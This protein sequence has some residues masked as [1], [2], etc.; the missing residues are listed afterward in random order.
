MASDPAGIHENA[1][2]GGVT[3]PFGFDG[4]SER[5]RL[6]A[7]GSNGHD[8]HP[9]D[10]TEIGNVPTD[11]FPSAAE[12]SE[13][14][15]DFPS[16]DDDRDR[17]R[18]VSAAELAHPDAPRRGDRP[19]GIDEIAA[20]EQ[21]VRTARGKLP[22][23]HDA[24]LFEVLSEK[25]IAEE[26]ALAEWIRGQRRK[27]RRRAVEEEL[28]VEARD[29][30]TAAV[31]QRADEA[32]A[33]WHRRA[34]AARRRVSSE[35][36]RLAQLFRRAEWSSRAL[37][38]VVVLGMVWAGV[39][40]QHNL[41]PSGDMTDPLYWLSY[42]I[43]AMISI[44]I[45]TIMVAATTAARWGRELARGKVLFFEAALLGTTIALN[46]GPHLA[47]GELGRAA[48]YAIAPVMVGVVIWLHAWVSARYALLIDGAPVVDRGAEPG[49]VASRRV[50]AN[51]STGVVS[52]TQHHA[53]ERGT[54][55]DRRFATHAM[56]DRS[57]ATG[58]NGADTFGEPKPAATH[59]HSRPHAPNGADDSSTR[60]PRN[61]YTPDTPV[62][63]RPAATRTYPN[64][65]APSSNTRPLINGFPLNTPIVD[66]R[67][68]RS[69]HAASAD[70]DHTNGFAPR[71]GTLDSL[72]KPGHPGTHNH[73]G[74]NGHR[75]TERTNGREA[76]T[77]APETRDGHRSY[78][79]SAP[80]STDYATAPHRTANG[81]N[82]TRTPNGI[83]QPEADHTPRNG[84]NAQPDPNDQHSSPSAEDSRSA[85][86][87]E[88]T[89]SPAPPIDG[90][91][92]AIDLA[93]SDHLAN[94]TSRKHHS[95]HLDA[96]ARKNRET[97]S[98]TT[99]I[100]DAAASASGV[101]HGSDAA[102]EPTDYEH[103]ASHGDAPTHH[104]I[105]DEKPEFGVARDARVAPQ[106]PNG[107]RQFA[108]GHD[109]DLFADDSEPRHTTNTVDDTG[110][111]STLRTSPE[112]TTAA[113][114]I[115]TEKPGPD[116][117]AHTERVTDIRTATTSSN[118]P[119]GMTIPEQLVFEEPVEPPRPRPVP[120][121]SAPSLPTVDDEVHDVEDE[122]DL[123]D[124][125]EVTSLAREIARKRLSNLPIEQLKE[126]LLLADE[127]WPPPGIA[128]EV[129]VSRSAVVRALE[130]A[131][132]L[133][134]P[135]LN[136]AISG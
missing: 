114:P 99:A 23:Q 118:S 133:R 98:H 103:S 115:S 74:S 128:N 94:H 9:A 127:S 57:E 8:G 131:L 35:D 59:G 67:A 85:T 68:E 96:S 81:H 13:F 36:A 7:P 84:H 77:S 105:G 135:W 17:P 15:K 129:G 50:D 5:D 33:R 86:T 72:S 25:E 136:S 12:Y 110:A 41:V 61:G 119:R 70:G 43:E 64:G 21:Q 16:F 3:T 11:D 80:S 52:P 51:P 56:P 107:A 65:H 10:S 14:A 82:H 132:K 126:I 111:T 101:A 121:R 2:F 97:N 4:H 54:G 76:T 87:P 22:L 45:I 60:L 38:S 48:E 90:N 120:I 91:A 92:D 134:G 66:R 75:P 62:V 31:I 113:T 124:D 63:D 117:S 58:S 28:A 102:P 32:D 79:D 73:P 78:T 1:E 37:I 100:D 53:L 93:P 108:N 112:P 24:A 125:T 55:D 40:V 6:C 116:A 27:Q 29:R 20:L 83:H 26:R 106:T 42:G 123:D 49:R 89:A 71:N 109:A 39:N 104:S 19:T 122:D 30:K 69:G 18:I 44:P 34:L 47:S 46:A 88:S 130:S 95:G